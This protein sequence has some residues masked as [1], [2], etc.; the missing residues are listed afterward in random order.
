MDAKATAAATARN[1]TVRRRGMARGSKTIRGLGCRRGALGTLACSCRAELQLGRA[2]RACG[3]DAMGSGP[4]PDPVFPSA[5][6]LLALIR[7]PL[8]LVGMRI[9]A[10]RRCKR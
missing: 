10:H 5:P 6:G 8:E 7:Q 9:E 4:T 2:R 1:E 3:P